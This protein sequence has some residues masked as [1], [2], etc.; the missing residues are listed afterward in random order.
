[1]DVEV[2][3]WDKMRISNANILL[4]YI[5]DKYDGIIDD[6]YTM[7]DINYSIDGAFVYLGRLRKYGKIR[8]I[9]RGRY[10]VTPAGRKSISLLK[11]KIF[12]KLKKNGYLGKNE[13]VQLEGDKMYFYIPCEYAPELYHKIEAKFIQSIPPD[14]IEWIAETRNEMAYETLRL[15]ID[16]SDYIE[17]D[18]N[19][20]K[21]V[22]YSQKDSLNLVKLK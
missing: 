10:E 17:N 20:I 9:A 2:G 15:I 1:M 3:F 22:I 21:E 18:D 4:G 13:I 6:S 19:R 8:K 16:F 12:D 7:K 5:I 14:I 11:K